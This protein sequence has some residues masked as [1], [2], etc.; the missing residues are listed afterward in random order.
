MYSSLSTQASCEETRE[1]KE[2]GGER[3]T[4]DRDEKAV[5]FRVPYAPM[6]VDPQIQIIVRFALDTCYVCTVDI[7]RRMCRSRAD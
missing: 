1:L 3:G 2:R 5:G 6:K 7:I 4:I